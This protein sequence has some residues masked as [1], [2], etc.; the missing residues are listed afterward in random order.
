[1]VSGSTKSVF[2]DQKKVK[3]AAAR[4]KAY[5]INDSGVPG[6][7]LRVSPTGHKSFLVRYRVKGIKNP[8]THTIGNAD[9]FRVI[10]AREIARQCYVWA[11]E[12]KNPQV[13]M[14]TPADRL[15]H[16]IVEDHI[17][18]MRER[19]SY[20]RILSVYRCHIKPH[21]PN[22]RARDLLASD[23]SEIIDALHRK[24]KD[25][26]AGSVMQLVRAAWRRAGLD[27]VMFA[28]IHTTQGHKRSR[29][30]SMEELGRLFDVFDDW[31]ER[32]NR[33]PYMAYLPRLVLLTGA[34]PG[35]LR[36]A[37][38]SDIDEDRRELV[39]FDHKMS[40]KTKEPRRI[41]LTEMAWDMLADVPRLP[42]NDHILPGKRTGRPIAHYQN[43]WIEM[44]FEAN[45]QELTMYD[46]RRTYASIA[47]SLGEGR[48]Q[49]ARALGH[50]NMS[51]I[52]HYAWLS[53]EAARLIS[54][55]VAAAMHD[56]A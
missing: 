23:L 8:V 18:S 13:E 45:V 1:M 15:W 3:S 53:P 21:W 44:C 39:I 29:F 55:R 41:P 24:G 38:W 54:Q 35:E 11:R 42:N 52:D 28:G 25:R 34:R 19:A 9:S 27:P 22:R 51:A 33:W 36:K 5:F 30:A 20:S 31:L 32:P 12:G 43:V 48:D 56:R 49:I 50:S 40:R 7:F 47:L 2:L 17:A 16:H 14:V 26:T 6:F 46:L 37:K 10:E 4:D